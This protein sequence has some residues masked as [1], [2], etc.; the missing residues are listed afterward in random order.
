M[1]LDLILPKSHHTTD[2]AKERMD[3]DMLTLATKINYVN[4]VILW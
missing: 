1:L 4:W 2:H 3:K